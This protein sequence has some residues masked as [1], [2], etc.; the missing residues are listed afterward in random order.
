MQREK[1]GPKQRDVRVHLCMDFGNPFCDF[2]QQELGRL[3]HVIGEELD[4]GK[5]KNEKAEWEEGQRKN[6][7]DEPIEQDGE[8]V[9][10]CEGGDQRC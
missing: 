10:E 1:V 8:G 9:H 6:R 3:P 4:E 7:A 2:N 5:Q